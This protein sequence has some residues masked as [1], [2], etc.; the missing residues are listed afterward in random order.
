MSLTFSDH[1]A[2]HRALFDRLDTLGPALQ[3]AAAICADSLSRG[4]KLLFCGNGGSAADSQHLASEFVGRFVAE[5]R[6]LPAIALSTDSSAL[7]AIGNDYG[8]D[9][10]FERPLRAHGRPGDVVVGIS[11]SGRS[12]NVRRAMQ[13]ARELGL[14]T[15]GFLGHDGGTIAALCDVPLVVPDEVTARIQEAHIFLGHVLCAE[16]E[17]LLKL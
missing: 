10:V 9:Q 13:A 5:R 3:R 7:T 2:A 14:A 8:F 17:A 16:V 6:P 12:P 4:G 1:L 15:V 11:T